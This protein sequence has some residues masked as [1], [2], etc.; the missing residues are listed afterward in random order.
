MVGWEQPNRAGMKGK[1]RK[2]K[3]NDL[4]PGNCQ[5]KLTINDEEEG[6]EGQSWKAK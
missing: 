6:K 3:K 5:R 2:M 1:L 4:P